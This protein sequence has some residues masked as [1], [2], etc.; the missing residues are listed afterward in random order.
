VLRE[1]RSGRGGAFVAVGY[2]VS[3][4]VGVRAVAVL[5]AVGYAVSVTIRGGRD[6]AGHVVVVAI[7]LPGSV[8]C[9]GRPSRLGL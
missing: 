4:P 2:A 8:S 3:V 7:L 5:V 9:G 6:R 1:E